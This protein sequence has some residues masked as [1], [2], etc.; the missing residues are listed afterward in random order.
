MLEALQ[1]RDMCV[2][3]DDGVTVFEPHCQSRLSSHARACVVHHP[4]P[5]TLDLD[6]TLT[7]Q[8][9]LDRLLVH[10]SVHG[11]DLRPDRPQFAEERA[12]DEVTT[13]ENQLG[14]S[15]LF[16]ALVRQRSPAAGQMRIGDDRDAR[17]DAA[18]GSDATTIGSRR[19]LPAFHTSS[20]SA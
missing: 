15:K 4:D 10:V 12:R 8:R 5:D 13:V 11:L 20:P 1:L 17:Q 19:N 3:V 2:A 18:T 7:Q 16:H 9:S 6:D 14:T